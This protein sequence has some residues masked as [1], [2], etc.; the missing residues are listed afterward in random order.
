MTFIPWHDG[1]Y[2]YS[3]PHTSCHEITL[4]IVLPHDR[5]TNCHCT[6]K[7]KSH[8]TTDGLAIME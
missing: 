3:L 1:M 4:L 7:K 8:D 2:V 6:Q 5:L